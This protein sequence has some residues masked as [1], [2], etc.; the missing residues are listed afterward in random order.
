MAC[1]SR[2]I[3]W[4]RRG[5]RLS[6]QITSSYRGF[7]TSRVM[8]EEQVEELKRNPFYDKY[9]DKIAKLQKTSPEEFLSRLSAH[10]EKKKVTTATKQEKDFSLPGKPRMSVPSQSSTKSLD[11][12]MKTELLQDKTAEEITQIWTKHFAEQDKICAVI[13]RDTYKAMQHRFQQFNTFLF[14]VPRKNGYEFVVVQFQGDE[15]HFTT[16]INY[17]AHK[18]NAPECLSLMHYTELAE[19]KGLVLMVGEFDKDSLSVM[20]AKCLADQ[21]ELYYSRPSATKLQL[22]QRFHSEPA[23][24][25]HSDLIDELNQ[26]S[27]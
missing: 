23:M 3:G 17:Q 14:P 6:S 16:L 8:S 5:P 27:L 22:M 9:A 24:F 11:K 18:E 26:L 12:I 7:R 2:A 10:E 19:S 4:I 21:V 20:E 1:C 25:K 13:P 15:A